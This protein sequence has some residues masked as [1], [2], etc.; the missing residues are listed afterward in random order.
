MNTDDLLN[1]R[2]TI[3]DAMLILRQEGKTNVNPAKIYVNRSILSSVSIYF[4]NLFYWGTSPEKI[5]EE[6]KGEKCSSETLDLL[7]DAIFS[8][9]EMVVK[10]ID[11]FSGLIDS[12]Y[13]MDINSFIL[14]QNCEDALTILEMCL[15]YFIKVPYIKILKEFEGSKVGCFH[16]LLFLLDSLE[17]LTEENIPWISAWVS[18]KSE[19]KKIKN[20]EYVKKIKKFMAK[21]L[22]IAGDKGTVAIYDY[23]DGSMLER[24]DIN[25]QVSGASFSNSLN[26]LVL[27]I[28]NVVTIYDHDLSFVDEFT[29]KENINKISISPNGV[30]AAASKNFITFRDI[31]NYPAT[32]FKVSISS[33]KDIEWSGSNKFCIVSTEKE[34]KV[35]NLGTGNVIRSLHILAEFDAPRVKANDLFVIVYSENSKKIDIFPMGEFES[36]NIKLKPLE[37]HANVSSVAISLDKFEIAVHLVDDTLL[38]VDLMSRTTSYSQKSPGFLFSFTPENDGVGLLSSDKVTIQYFDKKFVQIT[39]PMFNEE[40]LIFADFISTHTEHGPIPIE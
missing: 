22:I 29:V 16:H 24:I 11:L 5:V 13:V 21:K 27:A 19:L 34:V 28:A 18:D 8:V 14:K 39:P 23:E 31:N 2:H 7:R 25:E 1:T 37:F 4:R 9:K 15:Q 38:V 6:I 32:S 12:I 20:K 35:I 10:N 36:F 3:P 26:L 33:V 17:E 30:V 40:K